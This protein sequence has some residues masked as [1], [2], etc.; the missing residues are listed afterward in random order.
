MDEPSPS[1]RAPGEDDFDAVVSLLIADELANTG[2]VVLDADFVRGGWSRP[3]F[4]LATDAW[5][6]TDAAGSVV[7][8]AQ[9]VREEPDLVGSW[10]LVHPDRRG[11]GVGSS[12]LDRIEARAAQLLAG[13]EA[14]RLR[15]S[16][17]A[18]DGAAAELLHAH[19]FRPVRHFWHMRIDLGGTVDVVADPDGVAIGGIHPARDLPAVHGVLQRAFVG[20]WGD[21]PGPYD[22]W[23]EEEVA[24]PSH[25]PSLWLLARDGGEPVGTL[26]AGQS[27]GRGW[28]DFLGVVP[29]HRGRGIGAALLQRAFAAFAERELSAALVSVDAENPTGATALYERVGMRVV[30]RWDL[31]ERSGSPS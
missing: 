22:R 20:D 3:G 6:A 24:S 1:L 14:P 9:V 28:I 19:G 2:E 23:L 21:Y 11:D 27:E 30:K 15:H 29:S 4:D 5:V 13:V 17:N 7:G 18:N 10:G 16:I 25:D 26:T 12:L 31:W 8:Y